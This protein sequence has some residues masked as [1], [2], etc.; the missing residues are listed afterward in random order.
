MINK[1]SRIYVAGHK[2]LVGSAIIRKLK[3]HGYK[4]I[5]TAKR[6]VLDLTD[7]KK[8]FNFL[9]KKNPI[10]YLFVQQRSGAFLL[11]ILTEVS[12][13]SKIYKS[14]I[15]LYMVHIKIILKDLFF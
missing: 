12:L 10:L 15:I 5:I 4:K 7:Q 1:N 8:T 9:K 14:K 3:Q 13:Y 6:K 2:G 11:I